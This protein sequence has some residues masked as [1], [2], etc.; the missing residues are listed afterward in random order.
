MAEL[1]NIILTRY[2]SLAAIIILSI[3]ILNILRI[4]L[5]QKTTTL[6]KTILILTTIIAAVA[7][8][9][10]L[11]VVTTLLTPIPRTPHIDGSTTLA[12]LVADTPTPYLKGLNIVTDEPY[13]IHLIPERFSAIGT[14]IPASRTIWIDK[15][16]E[17]DGVWL[18]EIGHHLWYYHLTDTERTTFTTLHPTS[19]PTNYSTTSVEEDFA[20]SFAIYNGAM[21]GMLDSPRWHFINNVTT[22]IIARDSR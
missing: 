17:F 19:P 18:H 8:T 12:R 16:T 7:I 9:I 20:E 21:D 14:Y 3:C 4:S 15:N 13:T 1:A 11:P 22:H 10:Q 6:G 5:R 2:V